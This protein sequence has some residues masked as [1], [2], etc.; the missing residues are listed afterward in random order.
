MNSQVYNYT[1]DIPNNLSIWGLIQLQVC[2]WKVNAMAKKV[3]TLDPKDC[4]LGY[5]WDSM[6]T[7]TW[8]DNNISN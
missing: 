1:S 6:T 4:Y 7:Q 3:S 8:I 5:Y 2:L